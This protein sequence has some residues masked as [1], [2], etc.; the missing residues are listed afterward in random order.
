MMQNVVQYRDASIDIQDV[1]VSRA[2][3]VI[4]NR[5]K[6]YK[7]VQIDQLIS[8]F[9]ANGFGL[10]HPVAFRFSDGSCSIV[11]PPVLEAT[12]DGMVVIEG[13]TRFYQC[14][15]S[16]ETSVKAVVVRGVEAD[17]PCD[18][19][20]QIG[21]VRVASST[22]GLPEIIP[23]VESKRRLMRRIENVMHPVE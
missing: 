9:T 21:D 1:L 19:V 4:Q 12:G 10:F 11:T 17:L 16:R 13:L 22:F 20:M 18:A 15:Q 2:L 5:V 14:V 7:L 3:Q 8:A 6:E 23:G